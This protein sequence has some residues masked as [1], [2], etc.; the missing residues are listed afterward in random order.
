MVRF[1]A[2]LVLCVNIFSSWLVHCEVQGRS[3]FV[4]VLDAP[5]YLVRS[6]KVVD[7]RNFTHN[8][9]EN[10]SNA[11]F[12]PRKAFSASTVD[13]H[14][15]NRFKYFILKPSQYLPAIC[16]SIL[17]V[18]VD[19]INLQYLIKKKT[20]INRMRTRRADKRWTNR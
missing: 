9:T 13:D 20:K 3:L 6:P 8:G 15:K 11:I 5:N 17:T 7:S 14:L 18:F 19:T 10:K 12:F 2:M 16:R 1:L 4:T